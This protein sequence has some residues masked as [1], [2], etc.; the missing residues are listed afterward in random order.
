MAHGLAAQ[1]VLQLDN[2]AISC[3]SMSHADKKFDANH[4]GC[5]TRSTLHASHGVSP[6]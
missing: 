6:P 4:S 5:I 1:P 3:E 2:A